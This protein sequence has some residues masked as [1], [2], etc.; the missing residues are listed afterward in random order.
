METWLI[1]LCC[2]LGNG[3]KA[4]SIRAIFAGMD[5][6]NCYKLLGNA[7]ASDDPE[8]FTF[9]YSEVNRGSDMLFY[10]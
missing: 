2:R 7:K 5:C 8:L 3:V 6:E 4:P 1:S 9:F 10:I